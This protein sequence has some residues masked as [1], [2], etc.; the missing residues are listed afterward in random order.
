VRIAAI[1][2][3]AVG[4]GSPAEARPNADVVIVWAPGQRL[5]P[6][7]AAARDAGA[8][9][10]DRS[11]LAAVRLPTASLVQRGIAA[12]DALELERARQLLD[13]ARTAADRSGAAELTQ[14][15]LSDLF[16]YRGLVKI[17]AE[18]TTGAWDE[19]VTALTVAPTRV[20][21][22][23]RF[24][25]R[26][27]TELE[28]VRTTLAERPRVKLEVKA[29]AGCSVAIDGVTVGPGDAA[30]P[31]LVGPHWV[32]ATCTDYAPWGTRIELAGDTSLA[33][34]NAPLVPPSSDD[35]LI[36]ARTVG[37]K[38]YVV[39]EVTGH[40]AT[41]RLLGIDGRER[42][43]RTLTVVSS[44]DPVA[45]V[46]GEMLETHAPVPRWYQSRWVWAAGAA[47]VVA[48]VLVPITA[49][50]ASDRTPTT[51]DG[52]LGNPAGWAR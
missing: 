17:Q 7:Q 25:P 10:I 33:A 2:L 1:L 24:P 14:G 48:A 32:R 38:A 39:V 9:V 11:P 37:A 8:A 16:L 15:E 30:S 34:G 41:T 50:V 49:S 23:A 31:R 26:V 40:V 12:Y 27:A 20:L 6:I 5:G 47:L 52:D 46:V 3:A 42:D 22:P 44:L 51:A 28:R 35:M 43:R 21:D 36:Q 19:L 18:D 13:E 45:K 29:P 4:L